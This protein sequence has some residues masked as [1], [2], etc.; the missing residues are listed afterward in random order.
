MHALNVCARKDDMIDT[1]NITGD[2]LQKYVSEERMWELVALAGWPCDCAKAKM[3]Y[4]K[5]LSKDESKAFRLSLSRA[6][7]V[8]HDVADKLD[9][10]CGD[11]GYGDLLWHIVGLG[12]DEFYSYC[13]DPK[14]IEK[15]ANTF[16]YK[17]CFGYCIPYED[18][19]KQNN[20]YTI[21]HVVDV[22]KKARKEIDMYYMLDG[23]KKTWNHLESIGKD[24]QAIDGILMKFIDKPDKER[25]ERLAGEKKFV[26]GACKKIEK[27][28]EKNM[29]ELP[30]KFT[31]G[32]KDGCSFNGMCTAVIENTVYDAEQVLEFIN[33]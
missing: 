11:D 10:C 23:G 19:Y 6:R 12:K 27:F 32:R 1:I 18:D 20:M 15:L 2:E 21:E 31:D 28:F 13:N 14:K 30:R 7:N 5:K 25:L 24:L 4:V 9:L 16:G 8:I 3:M 29:M 22:A 26:L 33:S 17:E